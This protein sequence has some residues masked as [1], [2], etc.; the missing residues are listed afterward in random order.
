MHAILLAGQSST[1]KTTIA[2]GLAQAG[3]GDALVKGF[4]KHCKV[5]GYDPTTRMPMITTSSAWPAFIAS[6][7]EE[8]CSELA[9]NTHGFLTKRQKSLAQSSEMKTF[10]DT[11]ESL[12]VLGSYCEPITSWTLLEGS[13]QST[14]RQTARPKFAQPDI[15]AIA[16]FSQRMFA[17]GPRATVGRLRN[18]LW[19]GVVLQDLRSSDHDGIASSAIRRIHAERRDASWIVY[20]NTVL[21][22]SVYITPF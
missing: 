14:G 12:E 22:A 5:T 4:R 15:A 2:I 8:I 1:D 18:V 19:K 21:M 13:S 9:N 17:R 7:R 6:W 16:S 20:H 3:L 10:L 11:A